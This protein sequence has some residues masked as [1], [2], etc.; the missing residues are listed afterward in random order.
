MKYYKLAFLEAC[1]NKGYSVTAPVKYLVA[2]LGVSNVVMTDK[3]TLAMIMGFS[4][5]IACFILG[6]V[7][8]RI[9]FVNA[10]QEVYNRYDPY[11]K[12]MRNSK[13]FKDKR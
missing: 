5:V 13:L 10:Q 2:F 7:L 12:E 1:F 8:F 6:Y 11:V 9:N 4:Y 3:M